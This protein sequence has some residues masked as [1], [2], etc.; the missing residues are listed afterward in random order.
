M[1]TA[2]DSVP[3]EA[4]K[5]RSSIRLMDLP[6]QPKKKKLSSS[7][8]D[9]PSQDT[10]N[11]PSAAEEATSA[12]VVTSIPRTASTSDPVGTS[13]QQQTLQQQQQE[14]QDQAQ[15]RDL[16]QQQQLSEQQA[17]HLKTLDNQVEKPKPVVESTRV[18][19]AEMESGSSSQPSRYETREERQIRIRKQFNQL[20]QKR[21]GFLDTNSLVS[22]FADITPDKNVQRRYADELLQLCHSRR[23]RD[24]HHHHHHHHHNTNGNGNG[25]GSHDSGNGSSHGNGHENGGGSPD[26]D[27]PDDSNSRDDDHQ[28]CNGDHGDEDDDGHVRYD[29]FDVFVEEKEERLWNLLREID[30]NNDNEIQPARAFKKFMNTN[31]P[32]PEGHNEILQPDYHGGADELAFITTEIKKANSTTKLKDG[33]KLKLQCEMNLMLTLLKEKGVRDPDVLGLLVQG[34]YFE[35][36]EPVQSSSQRDAYL[37]QSL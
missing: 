17:V 16:Q 19:T 35:M 28:N 34:T 18:T 2:F 12:R 10:K 5:D 15:D 26:S 13:D 9:T 3:A 27:S 7:S 8:P 33:D 30:H 14:A 24:H 4:A 31:L 21:S 25:N 6:M 1:S 37:R 22:F 11:L 32:M 29:D 36:S 23:S 20:D